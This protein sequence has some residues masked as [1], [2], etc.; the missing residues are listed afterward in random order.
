MTEIDPVDAYTRGFAYVE[1]WRGRITAEMAEFWG[2]P[3]M[4][5]R[6][7]AVVG[8][9]GFNR[10]LFRIVELGDDFQQVAYHET[11]GWAALEIHVR[12]PDALVS[13]LERL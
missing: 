5:D 2:V 6:E 12:S 4:V 1:L 8:P 9:P 3:A 10:G 13:Q 7:A 11:L